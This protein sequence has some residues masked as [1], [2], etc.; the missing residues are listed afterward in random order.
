MV[1]LVHAIAAS[2]VLALGPV[3]LLRRRRD[4]AHRIIGVTWYVAM[5]TTCFSSFGIH[6]HGFSWLHG[7]AIFTIVTSTLG[8]VG[9]VR[10][11]RQLHRNNMIGSYLGTSVAFL[12]AAFMPNRLIARMAVHDPGSLVLTATLVLATC[13]VFVTSV[14]RLTGRRRPRVSALA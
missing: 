14:L 5:L 4:R 6:P 10:H 11:I 3:Q 12:F 2:F 8:V 7:L 1:I 9:A 13:A